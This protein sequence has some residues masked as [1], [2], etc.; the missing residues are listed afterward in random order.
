M[1]FFIIYHLT[2]IMFIYIIFTIQEF[3]LVEDFFN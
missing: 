2:I 3:V 1:N